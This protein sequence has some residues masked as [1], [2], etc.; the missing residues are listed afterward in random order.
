MTLEA[1]YEHNTASMDF[2]NILYV[3]LL[4]GMELMAT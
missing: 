2:S 4:R 3:L 1:T